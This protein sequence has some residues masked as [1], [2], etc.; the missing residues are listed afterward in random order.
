MMTRTCPEIVSTGLALAL[1]VIALPGCGVKPVAGGTKGTLRAGAEMLRDIQLTVHQRD[2]DAWRQVGFGITGPDGEF[3]LVTPGAKGALWLTPG[4]YRCTLESVGAP[5]RIPKE[6][7]QAGTTPLKITWTE[8]DDA[9]AVEV[10]GVA[11]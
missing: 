4:E 5:V 7:S 6:Y 3:E 1:I 2:S 9:L 10:V 8:N 11:P